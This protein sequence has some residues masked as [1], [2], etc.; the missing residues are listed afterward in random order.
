[1]PGIISGGLN[2]AFAGGN[3]LGGTVA[4]ISYVSSV[5]E[6]KMTST[7]MES[8]GYK[9]LTSTD[10]NY[11]FDK[12]SISINEIKSKYPRYYKVLTKLH[13]FVSGNEIISQAFM[14]NS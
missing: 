7:D 10:Y 2:S 3:F 8:L 6:N 5:F 14:D 9:Y 13:S 12:E 4:G 1:L 11:S